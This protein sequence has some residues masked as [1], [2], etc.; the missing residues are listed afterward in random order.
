M[1][2]T[3]PPF[4][5]EADVIA[6][7]VTL[8]LKTLAGTPRD[9]VLYFPGWQR[10]ALLGE[11]FIRDQNDAAILATVLTDGRAKAP[12][13]PSDSSNPQSAIR[14]PKSQLQGLDLVSIARLRDTALAMILGL[15]TMGKMLASMREAA[16]AATPES[17]SPAAIASPSAVPP[18]SVPVSWDGPASDSS[19]PTESSPASKPA[20]T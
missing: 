12:A 15:E 1:Q 11:R 5:T 8:P 18:P 10:Q 16:A 14:N 20:A 9:V 17:S 6:G 2:T 7:H 3:P 19:P 13:E 4:Y